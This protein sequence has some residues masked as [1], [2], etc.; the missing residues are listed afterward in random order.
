MEIASR[1]LLVKT[2]SGNDANVLLRLFS[3]ELIEGRWD[4]RYEIDWPEDGW[5]AQTAKGHAVGSD[6]LHAL[7]LA[8]QKLGIDL[9]STSYHKAGTMRWDDWKG[10]GIALPKAGR[11]LMRG[12]DAKFYG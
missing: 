3:P 6:A 7:Q 1:I 11:D 9:H 5:P 4:C 8:M 2:K 12:D 10:Y